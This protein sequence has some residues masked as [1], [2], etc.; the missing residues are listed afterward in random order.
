MYRLRFIL[1]MLKSLFSKKRDLT[2]DFKLSFWAIPF[3]DTDLALL[4]TQTY[5]QYMGLARW[6]LVFN[7]EFRTAALKRAWVPV[8]TRETMSYKR[9][10][11]AFDRVS[12]ITR[13]VHWN[14]RRFYLQQVFYVRGEIR[15]V[16]YVEGLIRGPKGHLKP[17]E[18][19]QRIGVSRESAPLPENLQGWI[20][21]IYEPPSQKER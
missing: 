7:S 15:A 2:D 9:S 12:L 6:N 20:D 21:M 1:V 17:I 19:L 4:F 18:V 16:A 8:T 13:I 14:Q 10:I 5:S 3:L 11:R